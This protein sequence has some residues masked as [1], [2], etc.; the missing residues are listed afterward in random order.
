MLFTFFSRWVT[1]K[2]RS[3]IPVGRMYEVPQL[4]SRDT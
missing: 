2:Q 4:S 3:D 1:P